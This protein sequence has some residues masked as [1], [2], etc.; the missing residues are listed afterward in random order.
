M[1]IV[2]LC[3]HPRVRRV[4]RTDNLLL[5]LLWGMICCPLPVC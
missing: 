2:V 4:H 3:K 5:T 1:L